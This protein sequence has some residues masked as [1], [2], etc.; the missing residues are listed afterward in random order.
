MNKFNLYSIALVG[1][2]GLNFNNEL[3]LKMS[4]PDATSEKIK[5][6]IEQRIE[7]KV[8]NKFEKRLETFK[9][10]QIVLHNVKITAK[11]SM[12]LTIDNN[13][14]S[15][16]VNINDKTQLRRKFWGK[17]DLSEF[18]VGNYINIIGKWT[19][20]TKTIIDAK[21]IRNLSIQ[22]RYGVFFGEV[23]S[24]SESG[25]VMTSI[26]R[27]DLTVTTGTAKLINRK[28][29]TITKSDI[30]VGHR[31]RIKG[32]WDVTNKTVTEVGE[33]KDFD[34]PVKPSGSPTQ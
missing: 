13:G 19:D 25:F 24:I 22:K 9:S 11:D 26:H 12:A 1:V 32:L 17:S 34:L 14:T 4:T 29:E 10:N 27:E 31:V 21:L 18:S 6:R 28:Q 30:M 23:K 2:M 16:K 33:I 3:R 7:E 5:Q 15:V 8:E 20:D